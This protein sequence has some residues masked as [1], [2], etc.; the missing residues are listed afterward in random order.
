MLSQQTDLCLWRLFYVSMDQRGWMMQWPHQELA[1][2]RQMAS[3]CSKRQH[4]RSV[5]EENNTFHDMIIGTS[6]FVVLSHLPLWERHCYIGCLFK[7]MRFLTPTDFS[8]NRC[9]SSH[10]RFLVC[11]GILTIICTPKGEFAAVMVLPPSKLQGLQP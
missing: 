2:R 5:D 1:G 6:S 3:H 10:V 8:R 4:T 11:Y 7:I 9:P